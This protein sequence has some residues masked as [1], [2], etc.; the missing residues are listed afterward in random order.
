MLLK[1]KP[2]SLRNAFLVMAFTLLI[3]LSTSSSK[4]KVIMMV[5]AAIVLADYRL[6]CLPIPKLTLDPY[7]VYLIFQE[8]SEGCTQF[9]STLDQ[10]SFLSSALFWDHSWKNL[11]HQAF[12]EVRPRKRLQT[13]KSIREDVLNFSKQ[14]IT[15]TS[16]D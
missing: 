4:G 9:C 7:T 1:C 13:S 11:L 8:M 14:E 10:L 12:L 16:I 2:S 6:K 3:K 15:R 5:L